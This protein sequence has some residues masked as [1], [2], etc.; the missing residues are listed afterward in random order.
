MSDRS[1]VLVIV[2]LFLKNWPAMKDGHSSGNADAKR[3]IAATLPVPVA[4]KR[5]KT[6]DNKEQLAA[7]VRYG[8]PF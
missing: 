2:I 7:K 6:K 4:K 8:L 1:A 3:K 5:K